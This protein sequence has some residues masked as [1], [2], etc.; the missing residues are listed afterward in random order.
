[1]KERISKDIMQPFES[2]KPYEIPTDMEISRPRQGTILIWL[3]ISGL[4]LSLIT[5]LFVTELGY[6]GFKA[7]EMGTMIG[8]FGA[9]GLFFLLPWLILNIVITIGI[10]KRKRWAIILSI[11]YTCAVGIFIGLFALDCGIE[12]FC[13]AMIFP[14]LILWLEIVCL[15]HPYYNPNKFK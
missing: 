2:R 7:G 14:G 13:V 11:I 9:I 1:M 15:K 12:F 5:V 6:H 8:I 3:F 4:V 10:I